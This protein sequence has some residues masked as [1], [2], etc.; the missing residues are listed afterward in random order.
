MATR[1]LIVDDSAV[2]LRA[3]RALLEPEGVVV[4]VASTSDEAR[5]LV[6]EIDPDAVL[7]DI[8]LG[9]ENGF[10]LAA[11]LSE[12]TDASGGAPSIIL[13]SSHSPEDFEELVMGSPALGF[14]SKATLSARAIR[15]M[16]DEAS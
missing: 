4:T 3:A 1:C 14:L 13:I 9:D 7:I 11:E 2:F 10:D 16:L 6:D 5:R 12:R 15:L 8:D